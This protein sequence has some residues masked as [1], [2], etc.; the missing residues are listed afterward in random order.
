MA[1][2]GISILP[3]FPWSITSERAAM[4]LA[5]GHKTN[6]IM[7]QE[8]GISVAS[9]KDWRAAPEFRE[10]VK[11]IIEATQAA[12]LESGV[13]NKIGRIAAL[14]DVYQ[15]LQQVVDER[16]AEGPTNWPLAPGISTGLVIH[17]FKG[18][19]SGR[20]FREVDEF[21]VDQPLVT[22]LRDTLKQIAQETGQWVE[23]TDAAHSITKIEVVYEDMEPKDL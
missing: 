15:K 10:R 3:A 16:A 23:K 4:L 19:G 9:L 20:T 7:A 11:S 21:L 14:M 2:N 22:Q 8:L 12:A 5:E 18:L 17:Q 6:S 1:H 13:L